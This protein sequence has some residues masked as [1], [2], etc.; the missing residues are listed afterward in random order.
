[1][2]LRRTPL[3]PHAE[4]QSGRPAGQ[5]PR[6]PPCPSLPRPTAPEACLVRVSSEPRRPRIMSFVGGRSLGA[7]GPFPCSVRSPHASCGLDYKTQS[8]KSGVWSR[9]MGTASLA[10]SSRWPHGFDEAGLAL[11]CTLGHGASNRGKL[12]H[13]KAGG[14]VRRGRPCGDDARDHRDRNGV[15]AQSHGVGRSAP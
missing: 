6:R 10:R 11:R 14:D 4:P 1:M 5:Q 2:A 8:A 13:A 12:S 15:S 9:A 3:G 7:I